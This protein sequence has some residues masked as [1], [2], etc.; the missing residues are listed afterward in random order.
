[1][2]FSLIRYLWAAPN[3]ILG[4]LFVPAAL[5]A[6]GRMQVVDGVLEMHGP[7]ISWLLRYCVPLDG[8][9]SAITFGHVVLGCNADVL[10]ATRPHER[11]HV[12]QCEVWGPAFIPAY[13]VAS[14]WAYADGS[15][16]YMGNYFEREARGNY[17]HRPTSTEAARRPTRLERR[18]RRL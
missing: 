11:V 14:I 1:M 5:L 3:T 7:L 8:G 17:E 13:F 15:G 10:L 9:A 18:A 12:R 6:G 16:A 2:L 4:L